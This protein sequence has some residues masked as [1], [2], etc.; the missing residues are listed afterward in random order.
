MGLTKFIS[1]DYK[2]PSEFDS[3]NAKYTLIKLLENNYDVE[4]IDFYDYSERNFEKNSVFIATQWLLNRFY[5]DE[6]FDKIRSK[7]ITLFDYGND[8]IFLHHFWNP[9]YFFTLSEI[10]GKEYE[11]HQSSYIITELSKIKPEF[12]PE[13]DKNNLDNYFQNKVIY[14]VSGEHPTLNGVREFIENNRNQ[15]KSDEFTYRFSQFKNI[16]TLVHKIPITREPKDF[17]CFGYAKKN[18]AY[19]FIIDIH[20]VGKYDAHAKLFL[21]LLENTLKFLDSKI[22][23]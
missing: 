20:G 22:L 17:I 11:T 16:T 12:L 4:L 7:T 18:N 19:K 14:Q 13:N 23:E 8:F 15:F 5:D 10:N 2:P 9:G 3:M 1:S 6:M 21:L